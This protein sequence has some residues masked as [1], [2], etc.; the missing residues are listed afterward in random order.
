MLKP[1]AAYCVLRGT[2]E[3]PDSGAAVRV[4]DGAVGSAGRRLK[5]SAC[6]GTS[7]NQCHDRHWTLTDI[8]HLM[9]CNN[10]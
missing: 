2:A 10:G 4:V 3:D 5:L 7:S 9:S 6:A 8:C 1:T